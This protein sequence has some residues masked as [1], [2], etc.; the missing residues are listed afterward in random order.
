MGPEAF[1][2]SQL[3]EDL[4]ASQTVFPCTGRFTVTA[5]AAGIKAAAVEVQ[6]GAVRA[7]RVLKANH[8]TILYRGTI[9]CVSGKNL[10][11]GAS[12][13]QPVVSGHGAC[14][15]VKTTIKL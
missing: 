8:V 6:P 13:G 10:E 14:G 7:I 5:T 1:E 2:T 11:S 12:V 4:K 15:S 3:L 9:H